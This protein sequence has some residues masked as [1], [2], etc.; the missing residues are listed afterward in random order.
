MFKLN[1]LEVLKL[2]V[3]FPYISNTG[4]HLESNGK[5]SWEVGRSEHLITIAN[6]LGF[7]YVFCQSWE[8]HVKLGNIAPILEVGKLEFLRDKIAQ[9]SSHNF[10]LTALGFGSGFVII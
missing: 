4:Y 2:V 3:M 1:N 7:L 10:Y 5:N 8:Q 6:A 9:S